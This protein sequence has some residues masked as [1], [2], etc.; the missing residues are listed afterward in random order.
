MDSYE[1]I[2]QVLI[3]ERRSVSL[4]DCNNCKAFIGYSNDIDDIYENIHDYK[5]NKKT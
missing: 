4:K 5:P 3:R 2:H 1:G